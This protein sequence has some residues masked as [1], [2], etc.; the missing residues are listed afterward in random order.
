MTLALEA[1]YP[2]A[3]EAG[4]F[5]PQD[6]HVFVTSNQYRPKDTNQTTITINELSRSS[7][8]SWTRKE[9]NT[10][11]YMANGGINY[12]SG[13]LFCDQGNHSIPGGLVY[14]ESTPPY[15]STVLLDSFHGR[16]FNSLNDVVVK[17]DGSIW[18]TDPVYGSEQG[19]RGKP[20]LPSQ[21]YRFEPGTGDVR[22]VADGFGRPNGLSFSVDEKTLYITD[23][24]WIHGDG[25]TDDTRVSSM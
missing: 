4:V 2:F 7:N 5:I 9:V 18:F 25:T 19:I 21:V 15:Q 23:T 20:Q 3:H 1:D 16:L 6:D 14:M 8:Q 11:I 17:T 12:K 10:D 22:A 13:V 24:E